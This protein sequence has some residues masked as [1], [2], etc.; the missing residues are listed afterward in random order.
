MSA[1]LLLHILCFMFYIM[2]PKTQIQP[3]KI[4]IQLLFNYY[5]IFTSSSHY[6]R[7]TPW[8]SD[9][10]LFFTNQT[11]TYFYFSDLHLS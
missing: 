9:L 1:A 6:L 4:I 8:Y 11:Q 5:S 2:A 3:P 7:K 10:I